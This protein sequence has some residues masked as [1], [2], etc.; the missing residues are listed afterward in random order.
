MKIAALKVRLDR[1]VG[2]CLAQGGRLAAAT[3]LLGLLGALSSRGTITVTDWTPLFQGIEHANGVRS[4]G[5]GDSGNLF[6]SVL[7]IDLRD[8]D[9]RLLTTPPV[10]NRLDGVRETLSQGVSM[11]LASNK[12]QVAVNANF[13]NTLDQFETPF[14]TMN[15]DGVQISEGRVVSTADASSA[16]RLCSIYF[17]TNNQASV[18]FTNNYPRAAS[19]EGVFTAVTGGYALVKDGVSVANNRTSPINGLDPR[20]AFGI[21]QDGRYLLL[22]T[23]DG[24]QPGWSDGCEDEETAEWLIRFGAANAMNMD[25][26]G[27]VTMSMEDCLGLPTRLNRPSYLSLRNR[28]RYIGSHFGVY[29][30]PLQGLISNVKAVPVRGAATLSWISASNATS[31]V[32]YGTGT[33]YGT[34]VSASPL[35]ATRHEV[36]LTGLPAGQT[37]FFRIHATSEVGGV[38]ETASSC[39]AIPGVE[40]IRL[41]EFSQVWRYETNKLDGQ[42]WMA[43]DYDDSKWLGQGPGLLY[44]DETPV[45]TPDIGPKGTQVPPIINAPGNSARVAITHYFRTRFN[46]PQSSPPSSLMFS[47]FVDDGAIFYLNGREVYRLRMGSTNPVLWA[48]LSAG[49]NSTS[50]CGGD[51]ITV[52]PSTFQLTG[53]VLTNMVQGVNTMAVEVHNFNASSPDMVFGTTLTAVTSDIP[54]V[55]PT[56]LQL[57]LN[58]GK[59][60]FEWAGGG[61]FVLQQASDV[62]VGPVAWTDVSGGL[63]SSPVAIPFDGKARFYRL[64]Y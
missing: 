50:P 37:I 12:V 48:T 46:F 24:R 54:V 1:W 52:C 51:A 31:W 60:R 7:R 62:G 40:P 43:P 61:E 6:V 53:N 11:F 64:R 30:K 14:L 10:S 42:T 44:Y 20:T 16:D 26:G 55:T 36:T 19:T 17:S 45:G 9:I 34:T 58:D 29:A 56:S 3:L 35:P 21:S 39:V 15:V 2:R 8:P 28:E 5:D 47:N 57:S 41:F 22:M 49:A 38:S 33:N 13:F 4:P 23:I 25:G 18:Y 63:R 27:S 32:E 59:L